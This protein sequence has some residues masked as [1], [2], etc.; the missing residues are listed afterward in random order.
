M[1]FDLRKI[2][3]AMQWVYE[4]NGYRSTILLSHEGVFF[5]GIPLD[6]D[7]DGEYGG[8]YRMSHRDFLRTKD[9]RF[10]KEDAHFEIVRILEEAR[11]R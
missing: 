9:R 8:A 5:S 7:D 2:P 4:E 1:K 10:R 11:L 3:E 6:P